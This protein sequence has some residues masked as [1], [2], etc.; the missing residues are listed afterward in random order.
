[1]TTAAAQ[2]SGPVDRP[3]R[4][5]DIRRLLT[6]EQRERFETALA[7]ADGDND[8]IGTVHLYAALAQ[9][10]TTPGLDQA[11]ADVHAGRART[12]SLDDVFAE[13]AN[14]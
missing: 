13:A 14:Q 6:D 5:K 3:T 1:M 2:P 12:H 10:N 11:T 4:I 7:N 9:A 8:L